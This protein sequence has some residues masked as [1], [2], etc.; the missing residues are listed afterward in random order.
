MIIK[1]SDELYIDSVSTASYEIITISNGKEK[2]YRIVMRPP[3]DPHS[4]YNYTV[5]GEM[6][7]KEKAI[8]T[9]KLLIISL[10]KQK[11]YFSYEEI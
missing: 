4:L 7:S 3:G 6:D 9:L 2:S 5:I 8:E 11:P 1:C 10:T